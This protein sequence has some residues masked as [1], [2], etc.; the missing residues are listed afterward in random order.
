MERAS[1]DGSATNDLVTNVGDLRAPDDRVHSG[2]TG[3]AARGKGDTDH[4]AL[5][6]MCQ[7]LLGDKMFNAF[8]ADEL[9]PERCKASHCCLPQHFDAQCVGTEGGTLN[10]K[11]SG[12]SAPAQ[13]MSGHQV[14][15]KLN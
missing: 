9:P 8:E 4:V 10:S 13:E 1:T 11:R 7:H 3:N 14:K 6:T 15:P 2:T 12:E 5:V